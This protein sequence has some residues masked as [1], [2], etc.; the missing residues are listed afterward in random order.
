MYIGRMRQQFVYTQ[1]AWE[2][3][4]LRLPHSSLF[5]RIHAF[6]VYIASLLLSVVVELQPYMYMLL[7]SPEE[8]LERTDTVSPTFTERCSSVVAAK[9]IVT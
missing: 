1:T 3:G 8:S 5:A 4:R 7:R 9:S 6:H 2:Q